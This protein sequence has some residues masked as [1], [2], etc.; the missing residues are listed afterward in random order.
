MT[1]AR[2]DISKEAKTIS[3]ENS[4]TLEWEKLKDI[5]RIV[6]VTKE[7][8]ALPNLK[9]QY[10]QHEWPEQ[11]EDNTEGKWKDADIRVLIEGNDAARNVFPM[12]FKSTNIREFREL[13]KFKALYR[14]TT[15]IRLKF[16]GEMQ[17]IDR[18]EVYT[19]A[20]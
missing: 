12:I 10:W 4:L 17:E 1:D 15:K 8:T 20:G 9:L 16:R 11:M 6:V 5:Y 13:K 2:I 7:P 19:K 14:R 3:E 18:V